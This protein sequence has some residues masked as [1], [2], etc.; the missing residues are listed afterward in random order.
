[1]NSE[2]FLHRNLPLYDGI[3]TLVAENVPLWIFSL[4]HDVI[5]EALAARLSIP[6]HSGFSAATVMLPRR[7]TSGKKT[8]QIRAEVLTRHELEHGAM[9]FPNPPRSGICLLKIHGALDEFTFNDAQDLLKLLPDAPGEAGVIDVLRAANEDLFYLQPGAP[10]G[11]AKVTNTI[12][13]A[14]DHGEMQFLGRSLLAGA[15]KFDARSSQDLPMSMLRHFRANL[16][17]VSTLICIGYGFGDQHINFALR[18]WLELSPDRRLEI[19]SP[20][21]DEVPSP[22]LHLSPQ[23]THS[24]MA[25]TDYLDSRAGIVRSSM[26]KRGKRL[27]SVLRSLGKKRADEAVAAFMQQHQHR[28]TQALLARLQSLPVIN[29]KPDFSSLGEPAEVAK[30]SAAEINPSE[31]ELVRQILGYCEALVG[32]T[33]P[34]RHLRRGAKDRGGS[35]PS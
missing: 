10:G 22:L 6:V 31:E 2:T 17:F 29:G 14:D 12:T 13:Y 7:N 25:A 4:N 9:H 20:G 18:E 26:E 34:E 3:R 23:V 15:F 16:N 11:K 27:T 28:M 33:T 5:V 8:G 35:W 1:V 30:Q 32:E 19:V 24:A 21:V